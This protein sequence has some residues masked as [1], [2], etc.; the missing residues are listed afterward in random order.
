MK[1]TASYKIFFLFPLVLSNK[2]I[3]IEAKSSRSSVF[4]SIDG[5][6]VYE[7]GTEGDSTRGIHIV[8]INQ[9]TG[10]IMAKRVFDTYIPK[11]DEAMVL[12]LNMLAEGRIVV[13]MIKVCLRYQPP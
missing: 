2:K 10:I 11:E 7:D 9:V 3:K 13:F 8:V 6:K 12:F 1:C 5:L 4:V